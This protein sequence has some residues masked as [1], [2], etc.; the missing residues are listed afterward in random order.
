M[1][2]W[3]AAASQNTG[4]GLG[5]MLD[6]GLNVIPPAVFVLGAGALTLGMRPRAVAAVTYGLLAWSFLAELIGGLVNASHWIL[7]TSL[8]HQMAA[9]PAIGP[10]WTSNAILITL[11]LGVAAVGA[12]AFHR[13]D[14]AVE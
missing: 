11:G 8:F 12:V 14:L 6:A 13:R 7:D 3:L 2:S 5:T 1:T 10:N 4:V 9:A